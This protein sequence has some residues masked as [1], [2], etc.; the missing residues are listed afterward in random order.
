MNIKISVITPTIRGEKALEMARKS[1]KRQYFKEYE[2]IYDI[3][4]PKKKADFNKVMNK[5]LK[6]SKGELIV[7]LQ[8]YI[9]IERFGLNYFWS[10]YKE[11]PKTFFTGPVGKTLNFKNIKWDWRLHRSLEEPL[12]F[13]EWEI[14]WGAAPRDA[15]FEIGGFDEEMDNYWGFD[16]VNL[17]L[18][19]EMAG[20]KFMN[21]PNNFTVAYDHDAKMEHP[22]RKLR[23]PDFHNQR[24]DEFRRGLKIDYLN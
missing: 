4:K 3:S 7:F 10:A 15:L 16:N 24:L 23:N 5:L 2:W 21:I 9:R 19:A 11:N 12:N 14:D 22:F 1:L 13:M 8:D 6:K 17:G 18:R 20:Y